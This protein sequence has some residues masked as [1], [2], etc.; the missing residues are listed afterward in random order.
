MTPVGDRVRSHVAGSRVPAAVVVDVS[1]V[2]GLAAI[3]SLGRAGAPVIALDHR[4]SALGFRSRYACPGSSARIRAIEEAEFVR[5]LVELGDALGRPAPIFPTH[6]EHLNA[7]ARNRGELGDRLP[8]SRSRDWAVARADPV[9]ALSARE[10]ARGG[11]GRSARRPTRR[12]HRGARRASGA[13]LSRC[14]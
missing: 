4:R 11:R 14:S 8:L 1:W 7:I 6:D 5:L 2:N 10:R 13:R 3:R 9:E 12:R